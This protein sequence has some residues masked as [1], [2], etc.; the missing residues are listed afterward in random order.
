MAISGSFS[1]TISKHYTLRVEWSAS[2]SVT[3]N[4]STI[5]ATA[6]LDTDQYG[7][8]Y[9]G[10][11][12]DNKVNVN[13][14]DYTFTSPAISNDAGSAKTFTLGN[15]T[16]SAIAHAADGTK[17][18]TITV[19]YYIRATISG[20]WY[21]AITASKTV[22]LNTIPRA[23][24]PTLSASSIDM[25]ATL[26]INTP[27]ASSSFTHD[28][29]Y[30]FAGSGYVAIATGVGTSYSWPVAD[31]ASSIPSAT[32]GVMTI[33]C[34][35]KNGSATIGTKTV[36]LTVKVPTSVVPTVSNL[37]A[38]EAVSGIA[39]KF[40]AYV[41]HKSKATVAITGAG[42]KGSSITAYEATLSGET[43]TAAS[44][45]SNIIT[46]SGT[47]ALQARVKDSRGRWSAWKTLNLTVLAYT[48]PQ[49]QQFY[50]YRVDANG[51]AADS[52][53]YVALR[54]QYSVSSLNSKNTIQAT[55]TYRRSIDSSA[56]TLSTNTSTL[57][58]NNTAK[59]TNATFTTDYEYE[60]VLTVQD[61][62]G[63]ASKTSASVTIPT[64][65]VIL[66]IKE[67]GKGIAFGKTAEFDGI[68]FGWGIVGTVAEAALLEGRYKNHDGLLVQWGTVNI[69]P[70]GANIPAS[71]KVNFK[72]AYKQ[73]PFVALCP[74]SATPQY[75]SVA[76]TRDTNVVPDAKQAL[77][78][79]VSRSDGVVQTAISWLAVGLAAE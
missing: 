31:L 68:D 79:Y 62:F 18:V 30:A 29:A 61:W 42:I 21:E 74:R 19:T 70:G 1:N 9:V 43:Y 63:T 26:T 64:D 51:N 32:S 36:T 48:P 24:T 8:L 72:E 25:G 14:K 50:A 17:S 73:D 56:T 69:T 41:Q 10:S 49:I 38:V 39:A 55:V 75:I 77:G 16:T 57:S 7:T 45:T 27:R 5:K 65:E 47:V 40:G 54:Q 60:L 59:P 3:N 78:I 44:F 53:T 35:T 34:I 15:I 20:T 71:V 46:A 12:S 22:T 28:L 33:R 2:Q 52:G 11:R 6:Y 58:V 76:T 4:T 66:D 13:S 67:N 37:T 23:T